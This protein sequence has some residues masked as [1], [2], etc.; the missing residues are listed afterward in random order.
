MT[1]I[2]RLGAIVLFAT[3]PFA[4]R[5]ESALERGRYLVN[6]IA[7]CGNCHTPPVPTGGR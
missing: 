2:L 5:A 3:L 6:S 7:A 1:V 4:A